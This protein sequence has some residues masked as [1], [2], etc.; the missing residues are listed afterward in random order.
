MTQPGSTYTLDRMAATLA[1][2]EPV[3]R[4]RLVSPARAR[5][6]AALGIHTVRDLVAH[7]PRRY[8]DLSSKET[9]ASAR[10]GE[11]CTI[12]GA[13]HDIKLKRPRPKLALVEIGL[14]DETGVLMVTAFRQP[15]LMDSLKAGMRI[16]VAGK[17]EFDYGFKRMTNPFIEVVGQGVGGAAG[18]IIPV[19]PA[20]ERCPRHGC[21]AWW[22]TRL[23][24]RVAHTTR[25]RF[26]CVR[27]TGS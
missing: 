5:A 16:A 19:H 4:V 22:A 2:D 11:Q 7:Y 6:L 20:T 26:P 1:L 21:G 3:T 14:V 18:M 27:S 25:C 12:E 23:P 10:I 9:V 8:I 13:I 17:L 15:W 24:R